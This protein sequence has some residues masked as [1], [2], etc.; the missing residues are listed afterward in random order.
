VVWFLDA[1]MFMQRGTD[2][3]S[4]ARQS[5]AGYHSSNKVS[6]FVLYQ[7]QTSFQA[8][9]FLKPLHAVFPLL[10]FAFFSHHRIV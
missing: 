8:V 5:D 2:E 3:V 10:P 6:L 4:V 1:V 7:L 9:S